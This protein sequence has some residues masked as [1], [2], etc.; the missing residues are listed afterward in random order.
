[1]AKPQ[2]IAEQEQ[3][4]DTRTAPSL[5]FSVVPPV[6]A[7]QVFSAAK[8]TEEVWEL[9]YIP[10]INLNSSHNIPTVQCAS[11]PSH[12]LL[13]LYI[14]IT[15]RLLGMHSSHNWGTNTQPHTGGTVVQEES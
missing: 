4:S 6:A 1:M 14:P 5:P 7:V 11:L 8:Y 12:L 2:Y 3:L 13:C 9:C 15:G 10:Q